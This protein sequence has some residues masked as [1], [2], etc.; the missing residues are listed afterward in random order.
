MRSAIRFDISKI[1]Q[2]ERNKLTA[3]STE[4]P[5]RVFERQILNNFPN[6]ITTRIGSK[7]CLIW[8]QVVELADYALFQGEILWHAL[9][10]NKQLGEHWANNSKFFLPRTSIANQAFSNFSLRLLGLDV[11][12]LPQLVEIAED[13]VQS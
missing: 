4:Y 13:D 1:L 12:I 11:V 8:R 6:H 5:P 3:M 7:D 9:A 2:L 10:A